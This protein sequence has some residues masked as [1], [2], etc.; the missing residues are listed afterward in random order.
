M[1]LVLILALL[2]LEPIWR[3]LEQQQQQQLCLLLQLQGVGPLLL[4]H[5]LFSSHGRLGLQLL[6]FLSLHL[7]LFQQVV[8]LEGVLGHIQMLFHSQH[9][10]FSCLGR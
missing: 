8:V 4:L 5:P 3:D 1:S 6:L 7:L 9:L 2:L 10:L